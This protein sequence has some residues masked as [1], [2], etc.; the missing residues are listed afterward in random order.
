MADRGTIAVE[1]WR[2]FGCAGHFICGHQCRFHLC[3]QVGDHLVSTVGDLWHERGS[4]EIHARVR[5]PE[6]LAR[7]QPLLGDDFDRAYME[8]FGYQ[9]IGL[10]RLYETMVFRAGKP[11]DSRTCGCGLP[12][13]DGGELDMEG[14]M[15]APA[16]TKG[17][18]AMCERWADPATRPA[19]GA[20]AP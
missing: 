12:S 2:W 11:C 17:H 18:L 14:Y 20:A 1:D 3:T 4:R 15:T 13:I 10:G 5:D 7:N 6:W 9:E 16:A 8:R 19:E